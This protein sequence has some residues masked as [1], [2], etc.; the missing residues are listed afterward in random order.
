MTGSFTHDGVTLRDDECRAVLR[1]VREPGGPAPACLW[2]APFDGRRVVLQDSD[3][4]AVPLTPALIERLRDHLEPWQEVRPTVGERVRALKAATGA[5]M[6]EG[7]VTGCRV[8]GDQVV[9]QDDGTWFTLYAA[10]GESRQTVLVRRPRKP[11]LT[12]GEVES[13]ATVER[14][15]G[16]RA[17]VTAKSA[18]MRHVVE[19]PSWRVDLWPLDTPVELVRDGDDPDGKVAGRML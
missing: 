18:P 4:A 11:T 13:G 16:R 14:S 10:Y 19:L 12:L 7:I 17:L 15:D 6:G 2:W 8:N 5:I 9:V 1:W 3:G